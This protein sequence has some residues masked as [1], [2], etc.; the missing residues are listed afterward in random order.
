LIQLEDGESKKF[1][2]IVQAYD[3]ELAKIGDARL[4]LTTEFGKVSD[5]ATPDQ[6]RHFA[7]R[8]F[9]LEGLCAESTTTASRRRSRPSSR[10]S[11]PSYSGSSRR[12][13]I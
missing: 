12:W 7:D 1:A 13:E 3:A 10:S 9:K 2:P 4:A 6:A 8:F 5:K 11:S